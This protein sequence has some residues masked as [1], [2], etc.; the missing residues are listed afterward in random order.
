MSLKGRWVTMDKERQLIIKTER[1]IDDLKSVCGEY[2][3]SNTGNEYKIIA[4]SFLYKYLND[5]FLYEF[6]KYDIAYECLI[7]GLFLDVKQMNILNIDCNFFE[8]NKN[9][10]KDYIFYNQ[11]YLKNIAE[12]EDVQ[13]IIFSVNFKYICM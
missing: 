9:K 6:K 4:D 10:T 1:M 3:L 8:D 13:E 11:N 5:K 12:G 7:K 2:G